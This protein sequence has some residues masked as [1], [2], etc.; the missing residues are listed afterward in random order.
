MCTMIAETDYWYYIFDK[1]IEK[2]IEFHVNELEY[3]G[4]TVELKKTYWFNIVFL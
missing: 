4:S 2:K 3:K 1:K